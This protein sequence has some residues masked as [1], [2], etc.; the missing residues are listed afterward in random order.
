MKCKTIV[1]WPTNTCRKY[2]DKRNR[3][4]NGWEK[5]IDKYCI[6]VD[7]NYCLLLRSPLWSLDDR[8]RWRSECDDNDDGFRL[9]SV[10]DGEGDRRWW[11]RLWRW[12]RSLLSLISFFLCFLSFLSFFNFFMR[13]GLST[14]DFSADCCFCLIANNGSSRILAW[15]SRSVLA[16]E[17]VKANRSVASVV[18]YICKKVSK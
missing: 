9:R 1:R 7:L 13:S 8:F 16:L 11:W 5:F 10:F 15:M 2:K 18:A 14:I 4:F 3:E 12:W 17:L 6:W